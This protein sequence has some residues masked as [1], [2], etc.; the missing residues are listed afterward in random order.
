MITDG[1]THDLSASVG[2][3]ALGGFTKSLFT[4]PLLIEVRFLKCIKLRRFV[5]SKDVVLHLSVR[6]CSKQ[7]Q[8][9]IVIC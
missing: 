9:I 2:K 1:D 3:T 5:V 4:K 7:E 8:M 6:S